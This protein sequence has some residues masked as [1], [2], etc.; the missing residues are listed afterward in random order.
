MNLARNYSLAGAYLRLFSEWEWVEKQGDKW[1]L[2][3]L[4]MESL[5]RFQ[6]N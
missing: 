2:T 6:S 3:E 1:M 5:P 4:G